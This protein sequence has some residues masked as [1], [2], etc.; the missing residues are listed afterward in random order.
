MNIGKVFNALIIMNVILSYSTREVVSKVDEFN[1]CIM[2]F[3]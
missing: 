3:S 2:G 1:Y